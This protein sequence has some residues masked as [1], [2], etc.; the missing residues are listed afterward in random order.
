[1]N[2]FLLHF[3]KLD[4]ILI[5]SVFLLVGFGLS[6]IYSSSL[7]RGD[8]TNFQKQIVWVVLGFVLMF[9]FSLFDWRIFRVN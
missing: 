2:S 9:V 7:R 5:I 8:F 4:W 1:M 3:K 6:S